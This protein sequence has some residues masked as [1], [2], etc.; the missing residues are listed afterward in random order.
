MPCDATT[1]HLESNEL[2][3]RPLG[4]DSGD[5]LLAHEVL[6]ELHD[7]AE[8]GLDRIRGL[9]DVV[10]VEREACLEAQR[11]ARA[12]A[13]RQD[14]EPLARREQRRPDWRRVFCL[15]EDL[16]AILAGVARSR[17]DRPSPGDRRLP[18]AEPPERRCHIG[19][20]DPGRL[21]DR[22]RLRPLQ[23]EERRAVARVFEVALAVSKRTEVGRDLVA[24][25]GVANDEHS[26]RRE[27]V[28][29]EIVEN[30]AAL[31]A[32]A[33]VRRAPVV[34]LSDIVR[35][36]RIDHRCRAVAFEPQLPH[37]RHVEQPR[38]LPHRRVLRRDPLVLHGHL[39]PRK[40]NDPRPQAH[41]LV[42][43]RR[44]S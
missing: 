15:A 20:A 37:V 4:L 29:D 34:E 24:I 14:A 44:M 39:V 41:M 25:G 18:H 30:G 10:A 31:I 22:E 1:H 36:Q 16:H 23:R 32:A 19:D 13:H 9:V 35:H 33:R 11:I 42:V 27:P 7:P 8:P 3:A 17:D 2:A 28:H 40:W 21:E 6:A 12:E 5:C 26:A 43:E 38:A